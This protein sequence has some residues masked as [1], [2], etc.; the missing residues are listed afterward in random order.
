MI[1]MDIR[2]RRINDLLILRNFFEVNE[3]KIEEINAFDIQDWARKSM[4]VLSKVHP[5]LSGDELSEEARK[6]HINEELFEGA[7]YICGTAACVLGWAGMIKT[8]RDRGLRVEKGCVIYEYK[9]GFKLEGG[10]AGKKFFALSEAIQE[11]LFYGSAYPKDF[12]IRVK[13]VIRQLDLVIG[14]YEKRRLIE[15]T[16]EQEALLD[17][18]FVHGVQLQ[19]YFE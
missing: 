1:T 14:L 4:V 8:F 13:A 19:R 17:R 2:I 11:F 5:T 9:N 3:K 12:P 16:E 10:L 18:G 7:E 6:E 15:L